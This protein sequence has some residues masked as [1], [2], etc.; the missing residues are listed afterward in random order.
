MRRRRWQTREI[1]DY[2]SP[3]GSTTVEVRR[4]RGAL[5]GGGMGCV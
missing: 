2:Y 3:P 4:V 1:P 5:V